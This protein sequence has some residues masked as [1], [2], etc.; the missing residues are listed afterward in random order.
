MV[1][2]NGVALVKP[3]T[4]QRCIVSKNMRTVAGSV[5]MGSYFVV[6][7]LVSPAA[8][9]LDQTAGTSVFTICALLVASH[10]SSAGAIVDR[11][12]VLGFTLPASEGLSDVEVLRFGEEL[13][14]LVPN[15][16]ATFR[17]EAL[18]VRA[19]SAGTL[20]VDQEVSVDDVDGRYQL[21]V[22]PIDVKAD[23]VTYRCKILFGTE[24]ILNKDMV[25]R[26]G[27][28]TIF[29][30]PTT[31]K[32][33]LVFAIVSVPIG[34][35]PAVAGDSQKPRT[36]SRRNMAPMPLQPRLVRQ[37]H[38]VYSSTGGLKLISQL[39]GARTKLMLMEKTLGPE[40]PDLVKL[41]RVTHDLEARVTTLTSVGVL[42]F[43]IAVDGSVRDVSVVRGAGDVT[44]AVVAAVSQ[45]Q[46]SPRSG[47][48]SRPP[49]I[50]MNY[51]FRLM[52]SG[53]KTIDGASP[54][55]MAEPEVAHG[56]VVDGG[57]LAP[58]A[59]S[60]IR[61]DI[62]SGASGFTIRH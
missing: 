33:P 54:P 56:L 21:A 10:G 1:S 57:T 32:G 62:P 6:S 61:E 45:W 20:Q 25:V 43:T 52:L 50:K 16:K 37:V 34:T 9:A 46:Y 23:Y 47:D 31:G 35:D 4:S 3:R 36:V 8:S 44:D 29:A 7:A 18:D 19:S 27:H 39:E 12:Q 24:V 51:V 14:R 17:L 22:A 5:V 30:K 15:L 26:I 40:H 48:K 49:E 13:T 59:M 41:R 55:D 11:P 60:G 42:S 2:R 53:D 38:P 58:A 28:R